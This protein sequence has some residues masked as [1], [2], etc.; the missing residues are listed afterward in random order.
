MPLMGTDERTIRETQAAWFEATA[1]G[2]LATLLSL[3]AE[4]VV[5]LT[6]GRPPFGREEL[7]AAFAAG[8]Q[9]VPISGGG[10]FGH[11]VFSNHCTSCTARPTTSS[12]PG[13]SAVSITAP[14]S[15]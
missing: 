1:N 11:A 3:M 10:E 12:R 9:Q 5:F 2:D 8:R 14:M 4:D 13:A 15:G 6:P 7:A